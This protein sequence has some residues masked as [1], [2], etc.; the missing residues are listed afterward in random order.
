MC[1]FIHFEDD[2][3][4]HDAKRYDDVLVILLLAR[5]K[6]IPGD[7]PNGIRRDTW[8]LERV[9]RTK[10]SQCHCLNVLHNGLR[11]AWSR[12]KK[13]IGAESNLTLSGEGSQ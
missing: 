12:P 6:K 2:N 8:T 10:S 1:D 11:G 5:E 13:L 7:T 9:R 4:A 3:F